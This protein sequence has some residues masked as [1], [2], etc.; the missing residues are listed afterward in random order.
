VDDK[1]YE[2]IE[3]KNTG[4]VPLDLSGMAFIHGI[5]YVFPASTVIQANSFLVLASNATVFETRYH[6]APFGQYSGQLSN[7]GETIILATSTGETVISLTYGTNFP[8]PRSPDGSGYSLVRRQDKMYQDVND[9]SSWRAST[10]IHG[11]PGKD[12]VMPT[13][14]KNE[15]NIPKEFRLYQNYPNPFNP[16]TIISFSLPKRTFVSLKVFDLIGREV[17]VIVHEELTAGNYSQQWNASGFSS[18]VYFYRLSAVPSLRRDLVSTDDRAGQAGSFSE[19][20]K[21]VLLK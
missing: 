19:T 7:S 20:K 15:E 2:F 18:G 12:D 10:T 14:V 4:T 3:L 1:E 17:A 13:G 8:W 21:L 5:T 16:I 6:F 9:P 11:N